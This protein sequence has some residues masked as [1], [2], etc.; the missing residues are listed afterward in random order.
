MNT[1]E[2][3]KKA[4]WAEVARL[5]KE[6]ATNKEAGS[7]QYIAELSGKIQGMVHILNMIR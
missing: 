4:G 2:I 6:L 7:V 3:I 1:L 5:Q